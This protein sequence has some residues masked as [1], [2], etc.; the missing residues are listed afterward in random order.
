MADNNDDTKVAPA[1]SQEVSLSQ[2][3]LAPLDAIFKAQTHSARSFLNLV[4]QLGYRHQPQKKVDDHTE[5]QIN[6]E[7]AK[8]FYLDF[9]HDLQYEDEKGNPQKKTQKVSVPALAAVPISPL[10]VESASFS[11]DMA[12]QKWESHKQIQ[13]SRSEKDA[14]GD[15]RPW[16][17][18]DDP[19]SLKG[20][21][22]EAAQASE[23]S[24]N[25]KIHIEV[26]VGQVKVPS[27]L[28][29]FLSTLGELTT[30]ED[31]ESVKGDE[32]NNSE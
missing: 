29:R 25:A 9:Y 4:L 5:T 15:K 6:P 11:F 27:G 12:V 13:Q 20:F 7:Q 22:S 21:I 30:V 31:V 1:S 23:G 26:K 24:S 19:I 17:L 2:V 18:V 14:L 3:L 8:P 10:A 16:F 32:E 28:N